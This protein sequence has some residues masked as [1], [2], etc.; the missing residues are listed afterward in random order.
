M[1]RLEVIKGDIT[2]MTVD[3]IVNAANASLRGG[4]GVDGAIHRVGGPEILKECKKIGHCPVGQAVI[5]TAG[6]LKAQKVIHTVGPVWKGGNNNEKELLKQCYLN[7]LKLAKQEGYKTIAF[8]NIS[9]GIYRFP[10]KLAA[11]LVI[12]TVKDFLKRDDH[13]EKIYF[14]TYGEENFKLYQ[15]KLQ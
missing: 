3:V 6:Q 14:V 10:K 12:S 2:Q 1:N 4:G 13:F 5:T 11:E 15:Q 9:T 8:P 7:S